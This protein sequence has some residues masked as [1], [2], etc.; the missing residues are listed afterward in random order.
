MFEINFFKKRNSILNQTLLWYCEICDKT[1]K[2]KSKSKCTI[3][4]SHKHKR[5]Y[6][7]VVKQYEFIN[8]D[9]DEVNYILNDIIRRLW[10]KLFSFI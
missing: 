7:T 6:G 5:T 10:K 8:P 3:S 4:K 9:V 2:I 1:T